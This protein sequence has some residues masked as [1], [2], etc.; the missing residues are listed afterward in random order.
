METEYKAKSY[1]ERGASSS[2]RQT[3]KLRA[4]R[5]STFNGVVTLTAKEYARA[6]ECLRKP[7]EPSEASKRGAAL[8]RKLYG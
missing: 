6:E 8:L 5:G 3:K 1:G 4:S 7:G 2:G